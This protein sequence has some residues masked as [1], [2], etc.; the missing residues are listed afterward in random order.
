MPTTTTLH[1]T[2][3]DLINRTRHHPAC[4][5]I[6]HA[7]TITTQNLPADGPPNNSLTYR[8]NSD[9]APRHA[10]AAAYLVHKL[11]H[12]HAQNLPQYADL[13]HAEAHL[14]TAAT[15]LATHPN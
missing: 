10:L 5:H 11:T 1:H 9:S 6:R 12:R 2:L 8:Y 7:H 3:T 15:L 14:L 13:G 4:A